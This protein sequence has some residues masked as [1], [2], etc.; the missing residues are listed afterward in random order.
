MSEQGTDTKQLTDF[1]GEMAGNMELSRADR[2]KAWSALERMAYLQSLVNQLPRTADGVPVVPG[3][4]IYLINSVS[5]NV[6]PWTAPVMDM[7]PSM[8][9]ATREAAQRAAS[10]EAE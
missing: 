10:D 1:L 5:G 4:N 9:Y 6:E 3:M 7:D 8:M 2:Q